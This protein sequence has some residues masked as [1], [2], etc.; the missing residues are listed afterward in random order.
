VATPG[1]VRT[2]AGLVRVYGSNNRYGDEP[3]SDPLGEPLVAEDFP[4]K[5]DRAMA[6]LGSVPD[7]LP[8]AYQRRRAIGS[9]LLMRQFTLTEGETLDDLIRDRLE[10]EAG[11]AFDQRAWYVALAVEREVEIGVAEPAESELLW[12]DADEVP[13]LLKRLRAEFT[14]A[15]NVLALAVENTIGAGFFEDRV[16]DEQLYFFAEG[17]E[18][19]SIAEVTG[20]AGSI[21]WRTQL[22]EST[23]KTLKER[24]ADLGASR[25]ASA[26]IVRPI[27]WYLAALQTL[28]PWN[29][30]E[31][32][33]FA[34]EVLTH[35]L[36]DKYRSKLKSL[37]F[38]ADEVKRED[39]S[40][41]NLLWPDRGLPIAIEFAI[42]ALALSPDSA[43]EDVTCFRKVTKARHQ[44]V[45]GQITNGASLPVSAVTDLVRRYLH[46]ALTGHPPR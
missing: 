8:P 7:W 35:K 11:N 37:R 33:Y 3:R 13:G 26:E 21:T 9:A 40:L 44:L 2:N 20:T 34:L 38:E 45:H 18:P 41:G 12:L 19:L 15:L 4:T 1:K 6:W 17:K 22:Q 14:P 46:L 10:R 31:R 30:F 28:D 25:A 5:G 23:W 27:H 24:V 43:E 29:R 16:V 36:A 32:A 39:G 42:V